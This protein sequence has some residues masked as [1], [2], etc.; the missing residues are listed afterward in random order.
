MLLWPSLTGT[1][2][3]PVAPPSWFFPAATSRATATTGELNQVRVCGVVCVFTPSTSAPFLLFLPSPVLSALP[4]L[5]FPLHSTLP[6]YIS[7]T[8]PLLTLASTPPLLPLSSPFPPS[9]RLK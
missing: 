1:Q 7:S 5:L 4:P 2:L 8:P 9:P 3:S 6:S